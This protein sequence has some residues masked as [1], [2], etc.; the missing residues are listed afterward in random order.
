MLRYASDEFVQEFFSDESVNVKCVLSWR[1]SP[2]NSGAGRQRLLIDFHNSCIFDSDMWHSR[3]DVP[4]M[5][6]QELKRQ[7]RQPLFSRQS[8]G[9]RY[10]R[11]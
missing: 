10:L 8:F 3:P 4:R 1:T 9:I 6:L 11:S 5:I 2:N 7:S